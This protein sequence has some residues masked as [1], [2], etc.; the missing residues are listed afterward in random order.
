MQMKGTMQKKTTTNLQLKT[1]LIIS[2]MIRCIMEKMCRKVPTDEFR[3]SSISI[4]A[5][6]VKLLKQILV[7]VS[8][9]RR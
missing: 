9:L 7:A 8:A 4:G 6:Y 5:C 2:S 3:G 1:R